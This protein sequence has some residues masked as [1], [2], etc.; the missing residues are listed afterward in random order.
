[1]SPTVPPIRLLLNPRSF[2]AIKELKFSLPFA[3]T[4]PSSHSIPTFIYEEML[5]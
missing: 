4:S 1:M 3:E 2:S 5:S